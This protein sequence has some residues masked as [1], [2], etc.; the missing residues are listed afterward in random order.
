MLPITTRFLLVLLSWSLIDV[1]EVY[2][3][4]PVVSTVSTVM[5]LLAGIWL[6]LV[7][8]LVASSSGAIS[9]GVLV[10]R[11]WQTSCRALCTRVVAKF[12]SKF[13]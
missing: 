13:V 10:E 8:L 9:L 12:L 11:R 5:D 6:V 1:G 3:F 4:G 7:A 2:S